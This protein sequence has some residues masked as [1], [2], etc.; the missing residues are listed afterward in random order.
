MHTIASLLM[1]FVLAAPLA[2]A[3]RVSIYQGKQC[4]SA[5]LGSFEVNAGDGCRND[6]VGTGQSLVIQ[7]PENEDAE[8]PYM[9][10]LF[11]SD[12]CNPATI[13][14]AKDKGCLS[15][16]DKNY[17]SFEVWDVMNDYPRRL[18]KIKF[19]LWDTE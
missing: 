10:V 5:N 6:R 7:P 17:G 1:T 19:A 9:L 15:I 11:S 13:I 14:T 18:R 12:N 8:N 16:E 3:M 2:S 4:R